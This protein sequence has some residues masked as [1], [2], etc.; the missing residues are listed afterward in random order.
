MT[1]VRFVV[2]S[3][4]EAI[5]MTDVRFVVLPHIEAITMTDLTSD[6]QLGRNNRK[7]RNDKKR[8]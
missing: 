3:H 6:P 5:T 2:L 7:T 4:I 8:A 1:G